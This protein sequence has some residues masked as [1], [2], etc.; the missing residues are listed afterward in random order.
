MYFVRLLASR[1]VLLLVLGAAAA[2]VVTD[3][4]SI[5]VVI[6]TLN[7]TGSS[8][9]AGA[10]AAAYAIGNIIAAPVQGRLTDLGLGVI[11]IGIGA[12]GFVAALSILPL[13]A[14]LPATIGVGA[15][16]VMGLFAPPLGSI[17]RSTWPTVMQP[18]ELPRI[19]TFEAVSQE[20][21][22]IAGPALASGLLAFSSAQTAVGVLS[23]LVAVGTGVFLLALARITPHQK[24][25]GDAPASARRLARVLTPGLRVLMK[26]RLL[27]MIGFGA[28]YVGLTSFCRDHGVPDMA[29]AMIAIW[30]L[31]S[32]VGG[33]AYM[34]WS[35]VGDAARRCAVLAAALAVA[36][37]ALPLAGGILAMCAGVAL[38]GVFLSPWLSSVDVLVFAHA[39][40]SCRARS[41]TLMLSVSFA[42][43]ALGS[44]IAGP[45]IDAAGTRAALAGTCAVLGAAA[46]LLYLAHGTLRGTAGNLDRA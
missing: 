7:M 28:V 33:L 42:G 43:E 16:A 32:I 21:Y 23:S 30:G 15:C 46:V 17:M 8:S 37:V 14:A 22:W 41:F 25:R 3:T 24:G 26:V 1:Q 11:A 4:A 39:E 38:F 5:T 35:P 6:V 9:R 27:S 40:P 31:G 19:Y 2:R 18:S 36:S 29:G 20:L 44:G 12:A 45:V 34:R 13:A 10:S